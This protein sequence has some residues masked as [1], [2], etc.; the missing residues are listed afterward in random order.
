MRNRWIL[1]TVVGALYLA[2]SCLAQEQDHDHE[3]KAP[4]ALKPAKGGAQ[5]TSQERAD[6]MLNAVTDQFIVIGDAHWHKGEYAHMV[7]LLK[8]VVTARP[9]DLDSYANAGWLLWSM[10]RDDEA[11][12]LYDQGLKA[13][14]NTSYMYDELGNY[15]YQR[16][17][18][19]IKALSYY[20]GAA[21][22]KDVA[23]L[24]L[25][26]LAHTY[27]KLNQLDTALKVWER[28]AS[29]PGDAAA[30]TNLARVKIKI[31]QRGLKS[32]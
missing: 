22:K 26:M 7:N 2:P 24:T 15:Y 13:N 29:I 23:T 8:S 9:T 1:M 17:K 5:L 14:P 6:W 10:D 31:S 11:I 12:A 32:I 20:E 28:C 21:Q 4:K 18:N 25:H 30:K 3:H 27:E 19:Y 16:K